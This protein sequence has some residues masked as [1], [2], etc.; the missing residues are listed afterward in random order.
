[1][2][3]K[4]YLSLAVLLTLNAPVKAQEL[5]ALIERGQEL[6]NSDTGCHV[7]HALSGEGLVG[8]SLL[9]GPTPVDI[10]DQLES[11][12]VMGV[13]VNEMDPSDEDLAAIS[14]YI[15]TL[16]E[17]ELEADLPQR[18]LS[19]LEIVKSNQS[20]QLVFA[21]TERD[22][23]VE[24][25]ET[26]AS[27]RETWTRRS[28][29][30]SLLS[31]YRAGVLQ[32][33]D[34]GEAKFEPQ[35]GKTYFYENVGTASTPAVLFEGYTLPESNQ[36]V[37][38][39]AETHEV[40]ASYLI[41]KSLR[42]T[43]HT[44]M[45]SPDGRYVFIIGARADGV[46]DMAVANGLARLE[47]SATLIKVDAVTL[48]PVEQ[49]DIGGRLHHGQ[50]F[51]DYLLLDMFGRGPDG[52]AL[53]LFDPQTNEIVGGVKDID[54]GGYVYT[55]WSD[56]D[57]EY[58]YALME[59]AG[60]APGRATGMAGA[61]A[62]YQ[63][64]L[65]AMRPYWVAK[66]NADTWEVEKEYPVPGYRPNWLI[67]DAA[68]EHFYVINTLS[69]ASKINIETGEV[70][71]TNGTGI[72]PYGGS[73]NADETE[74][75]VANKGEAAGFSGRTITIMD[76]ESGYPEQTLYGAYKADH[77]LLSPN[78]KEMWAT[79]NAEGRIY[80]YD[81]ESKEL[82]TKI[83]MPGNGDAHGLAWVYY[84]ENGEPRTVRDQGNFHNG[85]NPMTGNALNA[86]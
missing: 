66:I 71:W 37:V 13:I 28:N 36:I 30:G 5:D 85:V 72:G 39:D 35:P 40:I 78:G 38:G 26:Y 60:Y 54:L 69:N 15:R 42:A 12:P 23:Q 27:V 64:R 18:W 46:D 21:M 43:V 86:P 1:M 34:P 17:M 77:V 19:D 62:M 61:Y 22:L 74:L 32:T 51:R 2:K 52:L 81:V 25:I 7:C 80:V 49:I 59:P 65:M 63:G 41:P 44:T 82:M 55:V 11:N 67:V 56:R 33:F 45:T 20:E 10:F 58:I 75:W 79:S 9:F 29:E 6:F 73:L 50:I 53:M 57:Y 84:D 3:S 4:F 31:H 83:D 14:M 68:K 16:A 24:A 8:P 47:A 70:V 76:T 48:Q